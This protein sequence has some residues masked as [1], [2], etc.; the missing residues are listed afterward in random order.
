MSSASSLA[1]IAFATAVALALPSV[2]AAQA[3][4]TLAELG[5]LDPPA[6]AAPLVR[7]GE[8]SPV[9]DEGIDAYRKRQYP[10]A[11]D[12]FRRFVTVEPDDPAGNFFLAA[13]LM[14]TDE[15]GEAD[16]RLGVVLAAGET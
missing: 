4:R 10:R 15:V 6:Y 9:F 3:R 13:T 11:A 7:G 8:P 1:A 2:A 12:V 16:D 5:R 14:M